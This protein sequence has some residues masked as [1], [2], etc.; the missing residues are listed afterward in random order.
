MLLYCRSLRLLSDFPLSV[1]LHQKVIPLIEPAPLTNFGNS[2]INIDQE[3]H[4]SY[5]YFHQNRYIEINTNKP[6]D[7][8]SQSAD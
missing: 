6:K 2:L 7:L 5:L 4:S 1:F 3:I 8:R